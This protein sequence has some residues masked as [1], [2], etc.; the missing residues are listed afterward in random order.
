MCYIIK[1]RSGEKLLLTGFEENLTM[2]AMI[3]AILQSL[4]W[5]PPYWPEIGVAL[6]TISCI[7]WLIMRLQRQKEKS[8]KPAD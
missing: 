5:G 6:A 8:E 1:E 2:R 3:G 4:A 7:L